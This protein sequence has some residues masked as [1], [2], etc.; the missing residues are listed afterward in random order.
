M[1]DDLPALDFE[2]SPEDRANAAA[3][4]VYLE[5]W[6]IERNRRDDARAKRLILADKRKARDG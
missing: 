4:R 1:T 6:R 2:L 3:A 5:R